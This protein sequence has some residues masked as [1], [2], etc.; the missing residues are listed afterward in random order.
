MY[1]RKILTTVL[2]CVFIL[3]IFIYG[4]YKAQN[5]ILGPKLSLSFPDHNS[6]LTGTTTA[7]RGNVYRVSQLFINGIPTAFSDTGFFET[8]FAISPPNTILQIDIIDK[9][10]RKITR[11]ENLSVSS[12]LK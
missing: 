4:A 7:I 3:A 6:S 11:I 1:L 2:I 12:S 9:F 5:L 8:R 10:G